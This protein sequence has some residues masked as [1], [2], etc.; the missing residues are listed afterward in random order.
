MSVL[1]Q[2]WIQIVYEPFAKDICYSLS[3]EMK[4]SHWFEKLDE[5]MIKKNSLIKTSK[6]VSE[7]EGEL[8]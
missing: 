3:Y 8:L 4:Q 6:M 1:N 5:L 2:I 7:I